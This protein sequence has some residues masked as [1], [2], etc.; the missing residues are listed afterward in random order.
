MYLSTLQDFWGQKRFRDRLQKLLS[1]RADDMRMRELECEID[2]AMI[3]KR[4]TCLD[5][6]GHR[7]TVEPVAVV[8]A[9]PIEAL[10]M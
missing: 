5:A 10:E 1:R 6:V 3:E 2:D 8:L 9:K 4:N 7:H